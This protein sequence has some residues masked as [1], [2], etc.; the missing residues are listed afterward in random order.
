[1]KDPRMIRFLFR[2]LMRAVFLLAGVSVLS[3]GLFELVPGDYFDGLRTD[4][5]LSDETLSAL[6][7]Q[8]GLDEDPV[9]R[10]ARWLASVLRGE[11]GYSVS[12]QRPVAPLLLTRAGNTLILTS[13]A[14]FCAWAVALPLAMWAVSGGRW[15]LRLA[16]SLMALLLATPHLL[17]LLALMFLAARS[18][19][20]PVGGMTSLHSGQMPLWSRVGDLVAHL[21]IP[22]AA[23][24]LAALPAVFLH[25]RAALMETLQAPFIRFARANGIPRR[26]LLLR[27]ALPAASNPLISLMGLSAGTLLSAGLAVEAVT[28]WPG[29]G[30]LLL[31]SIL[32]R[33]LVVV[34]G[35]VMLSAAVLLTGNLLADVL[36]YAADPRLRAER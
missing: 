14:V 31:Q 20:L 15:R 32:Q 27:H 7:R 3:F 16:D 33:D 30:Q 5:A 36:L 25:A 23:L 29:L 19:A 21:A 10:Y 24:M 22:G 13:T 6:R 8:H 26:R 34:T 12:Y 17:I 18:Q 2:R 28:G 35:A 1:M 4:P 9:R 11:W